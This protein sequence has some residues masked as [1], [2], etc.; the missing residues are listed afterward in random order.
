MRAAFSPKNPIIVFEDLRSA[1][2]QD[3]QEG[4]M[5]I[6]AGSMIGIRNPKAHDNISITRN[7][8]IHFLFLAS[9]LVYKVDERE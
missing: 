8:A 7:R 1:S 6:F 3:V 4:Y 5:E 2:G 9:L